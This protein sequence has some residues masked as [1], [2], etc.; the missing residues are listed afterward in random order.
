MTLDAPK[1][2]H[3][4]AERVRWLWPGR[5]PLGKLTVLDGDPGLG[6]STVALDFA[7]RISTA[8]PLADGHRT[9]SPCNTVLLSAEDAVADTIRPRLE[10]AGADLNRVTVV[11]GVNES[12][13]PR[14]P[15]LPGDLASLEA[16]IFED[17][18]SLVIVDPF[19]AYLAGGVDA[20]RDQDVRRALHALSATA[21]RTGA[22]LVI[23]RHLNKAPGGN[24]LYRGGG[25]I[26]IIGAARAGMLIAPDPA[27]ERRR[28]L[29]CTKSNLAEKPKSLAYRLIG[30]EEHD[31]ARVV[32]DGES[33]LTADALLNPPRESKRDDAAQ[34]LE[35]LLADGPVLASEVK[36]EATSEGISWRTVER[37]K[38]DLSVDAFRKGEPGKRGGGSWWW[39]LPGL[40]RHDLER[41]PLDNHLADLIP[42]PVSA[43]QEPFGNGHPIKDAN[44]VVV[45]DGGAA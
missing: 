4:R 26:G 21:E 41:Q 43:G 1:V 42:E 37:A 36:A 19:M 27:D 9:E 24:A 22:A 11:R 33:D 15:V 44:P 38:D 17:D 3:V 7:A 34:F 8:S 39:K 18:A 28:I 14:P 2:S 31:C 16:L 23:V 6:K 12:D 5:I 10:A 29:A 32:W 40:G 20:H 13:G 25:S 35:D 30:D 45:G